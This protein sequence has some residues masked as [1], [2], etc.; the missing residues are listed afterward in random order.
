MT[1]RLGTEGLQGE[2]YGLMD[3]CHVFRVLASHPVFPLR[4]KYGALSDILD[5]FAL[6]T[7]ILS[8]TWIDLQFQCYF[9]A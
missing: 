7:Y 2:G 8:T 4:T 6:A 1:S 3:W 5:Y 9:L